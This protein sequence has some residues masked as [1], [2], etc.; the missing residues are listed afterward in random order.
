[1]YGLE[2]ELRI[3]RHPAVQ[4]TGVGKKYFPTQELFLGK[5]EP[6]EWLV[7][8]MVTGV[9]MGFSGIVDVL[10]VNGQRFTFKRAALLDS[11]GFMNSMGYTMSGLPSVIEQS[12]IRDYTKHFRLILQTMFFLTNF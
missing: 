6:A 8:Q 9:R 2:A 7:I 5:T 10:V 1:M 12:S 11:D 3:D 4:I